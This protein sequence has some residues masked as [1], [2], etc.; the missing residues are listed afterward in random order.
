MPLPKPKKNESKDEFITRC[1]GNKSMQE[2]FEDNDQRLAVCNDLWEKN[3]YKRTKI[4]TEKR[5]F[6]VSELRTKPI[7]AMA[8]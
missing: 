7:D 2:E 1:M 8:T 3:K 4:D 5:F 6:V